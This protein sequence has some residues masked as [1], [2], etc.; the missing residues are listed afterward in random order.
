MK[1]KVIHNFR[2]LHDHGYLYRVGDDYPRPGVAVVKERVE[3]LATGK[4]KAK[5]VMIE[6]VKETKTEKTEEKP[7]KSTKKSTSKKAKE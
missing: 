1:Y 3:A 7:K 4:N 2:D 6:K 5:L